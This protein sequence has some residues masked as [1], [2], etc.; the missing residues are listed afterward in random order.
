M[1]V[2]QKFLFLFLIDLTKTS[3]IIATSYYLCIPMNMFDM[4]MYIYANL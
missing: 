1:K 2:K 3:K 4:C